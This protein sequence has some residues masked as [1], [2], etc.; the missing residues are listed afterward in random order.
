M[1]D[2]VCVCTFNEQC[3]RKGQE[4][5]ATSLPVLYVRNDI[6][7]DKQCLLLFLN[8]S[9]YLYSQ[10]LFL[11]IERTKITIIPAVL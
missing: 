2:G 9:F 10:L 6:M 1:D 8:R 3:A 11:Y 4:T 5:N 7:N